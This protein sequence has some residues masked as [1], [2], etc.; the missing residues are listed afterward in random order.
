MAL[1]VFS[2]VVPT[3]LAESDNP[4]AASGLAR[5]DAEVRGALDLAGALPVRPLCTSADQA[6]RG[7]SGL[8]VHRLVEGELNLRAGCTE[9]LGSPNACRAAQFCAAGLLLGLIPSLHYR[10]YTPAMFGGLIGTAA[11]YYVAWSET[12]VPRARLTELRNTKAAS[13]EKLG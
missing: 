12:K 10:R 11:D 6:N 2:L 8:G 13:T 9:A 3:A 5:V 4:D 7:E 1:R